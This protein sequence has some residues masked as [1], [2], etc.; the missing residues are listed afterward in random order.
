MSCGT[1][2][3]DERW[4][5]ERIYTQRNMPDAVNFKLFPPGSLRWVEWM[6]CVCMYEMLLAGARGGKSFVQVK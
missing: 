6:F 2:A 5:V 1:D 4:W 3:G